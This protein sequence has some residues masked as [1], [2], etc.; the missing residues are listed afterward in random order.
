MA[1]SR[2]VRAARSLANRVLRLAAASAQCSSPASR[3][4]DPENSGSSSAAPSGHL[5]GAE[6]P[7]GVH[8]PGTRLQQKT[9]TKCMPVAAIRVRNVQESRLRITDSNHPYLIATN[10][11][12]QNFSPAEKNQ[13]WVADF[14]SIPQGPWAG[15]IWLWLRISSRERSQ[16]GRCLRPPIRV[17]AH[18]SSMLGSP[19]FSR[20]RLQQ[21]SAHDGV[22]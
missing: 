12:D 1:E 2:G 6:S 21:R 3:G 9:V 15:S 10:L 5:R 13:V 7:P 17:I 18:S 11:L 22:D 16:G 14:T 4:V 8:G 20:I 19:V